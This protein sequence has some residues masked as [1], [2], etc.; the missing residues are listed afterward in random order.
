MLGDKTE[1]LSQEI[2]WW[3]GSA[4]CGCLLAWLRHPWVW[5]AVH[6]PLSILSSLSCSQTLV[7]QRATREKAATLHKLPQLPVSPQLKGPQAPE[8]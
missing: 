7:V 8:G 2:V 1:F 3:G 4:V 5:D 6:A